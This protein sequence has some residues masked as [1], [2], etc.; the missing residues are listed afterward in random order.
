MGLS[1]CVEPSFC[2]TRGMHPTC[3]VGFGL[4]V[5]NALILDG[6]LCEFK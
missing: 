1:V 5:R 6:A 2:Q 4:M 3:V